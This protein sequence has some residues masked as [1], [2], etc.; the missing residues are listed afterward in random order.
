MK[1]LLLLSF[2][3]ILSTFY[4]QAQAQAP[5][6]FKYQA[7][8]R[9]GSGQIL[10]DQAVGLQINLIEQMDF[11]TASVYIETHA[12]TTNAFGLVN[13]EIGRGTPVSGDFSMVNWAN[14]T[15]IQI[16][17]DAAGG[18]NYQEMGLAEL[19]SVPYALYAG[20]AANNEDADAD[21]TNELQDWTTL[22]G[23][24][25]D[26]SDGDQVDDADADPTNELE[27]PTDA[28]TGDIAYYDGEAW[29]RIPAGAPG[30]VL[31]MGEDGLP[32]WQRI[33]GPLDS[34]LEVTLPDGSSIYAH[35]M[36][37]SGAVDWGPAVDIADLANA[38]D[39]PA[40]EMDFDGRMNTGTIVAQLGDNNGMAYAAKV[41]DDLEAF[42]FDDWYLP[43]AG[44]L[45]E[46]IKQLGPS[47]SM[48]MSSAI[49]WS[50][51]EGSLSNRAWVWAGNFGRL[52][53]NIKNPAGTII[54]RCVRK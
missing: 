47:G 38:L 1:K 51:T 10:A 35:P 3:L 22:P 4:L 44:E 36:D 42:G 17:L 40:A 41:C 53:D 43:A 8:I 46:M 20:N 32:A 50:S 6:A 27:L 21:P 30:T 34:L 18:T 29:K 5:Q 45:T 14:P 19:L 48:E 54:C 9:D 16:S 24:P 25:A 28:Q 11:D 12:V 31:T 13:L 39:I 37:N 49:Y 52:F 26:I 33:P 23:I 7:V 2:Y 15:Y